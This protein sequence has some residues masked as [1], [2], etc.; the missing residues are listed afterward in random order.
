M[1]TSGNPEEG[2]KIVQKIWDAMPNKTYTKKQVQEFVDR[3]VS[4]VTHNG[5]GAYE[6]SNSLTCYEDRY[7]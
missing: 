5:L 4:E 1:L 3:T 6:Q 7:N 2:R